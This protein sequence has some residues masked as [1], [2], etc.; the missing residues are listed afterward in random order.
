M[1]NLWRINEE[2]YGED[3][4]TPNEIIKEQIRY[5]EG[6][7]KEYISGELVEIQLKDRF[8]ESEETSDFRYNFYIN[9]KFLKNYK[10]K[11]FSMTY[12]TLIYP[13]RL[14][15]NED[16]CEEFKI[17]YSDE[18]EC[19]NEEEFIIQLGDVLKSDYVANTLGILM[20]L[21]KNKEMDFLF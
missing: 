4:K 5:L 20:K 11:L 3:F 15:F 12:D 2:D 17:D 14:N 19:K 9:A 1:E 21:S 18:M 10:L 8:E 16:L 7:T 6:K 13:L